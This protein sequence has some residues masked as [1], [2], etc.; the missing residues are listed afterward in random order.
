MFSVKF[1]HII[2]IFFKITLGLNENALLTNKLKRENDLNCGNDENFTCQ[3]K[4]IN[5][6]L[7]VGTFTC[8]NK[9]PH[10]WLSLKY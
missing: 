8:A 2:A 10:Q 4:V 1:S 5:N 6:H 7:M 3:S 9:F